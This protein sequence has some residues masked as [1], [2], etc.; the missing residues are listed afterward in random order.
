MVIV[1]ANFGPHCTYFDYVCSLFEYVDVIVVLVDS[2]PS[3][4]REYC[5]V[6]S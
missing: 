6:I 3:I 5:F 4:A 1:A 2:P